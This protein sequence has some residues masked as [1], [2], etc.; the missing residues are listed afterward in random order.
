MDIQQG[1]TLDEPATTIRW[2]ITEPELA[3]ALWPVSANGTHGYWTAQVR[4]FAT[5]RCTLALQFSFNPL[6]LRGVLREI[7]FWRAPN[8]DPAASFPEL[9]RHLEGAFGP[10]DTTSLGG[11][12]FPRHVWHTGPFEI[13]HTVYE[14]FDLLED[15][16]IRRLTVLQRAFRALGGAA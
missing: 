13:V 9:Q 5:L 14:R 1:L 6:M 8:I 16:R 15:T 3:T 7:R 4:V 11:E 10:P 12:G 2:D